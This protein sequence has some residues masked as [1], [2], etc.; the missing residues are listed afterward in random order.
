MKRELLLWLQ[1]FLQF[2]SS[3]SEHLL[4]DNR[5]IVFSLGWA[6]S[7]SHFQI[8]EKFGTLENFFQF[9]DFLTSPELTE[10]ELEALYSTLNTQLS[11]DN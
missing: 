3:L 5:V 6:D 10:D 9:A 1:T 11:E 7:P 2:P 8:W 4:I